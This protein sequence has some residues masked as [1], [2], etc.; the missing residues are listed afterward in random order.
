MLEL[1]HMRKY[2]RMVAKGI[3][4]TVAQNDHSDCC[5][6]SQIDHHLRCCSKMY[7]YCDQTKSENQLSLEFDELCIYNNC[8]TAKRISSN[9]EKGEHWQRPIDSILACGGARSSVSS[10][11]THTV[12]TQKSI[13]YYSI[14]F[15]CMRH[16]ISQCEKHTEEEKVLLK[17]MPRR[18]LLRTIDP[19]S[20]FTGI[21]NRSHIPAVLS[22]Q[23][24]T[25]AH[26]R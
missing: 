11:S 25:P 19:S 6:L 3:A 8:W 12:N 10:W 23:C 13:H 16:S 1:R 17:P 9:A 14:R 22:L 20:Q 15:L 18:R 4:D 26:R 7:Q 5:G 21:L 2:S 24:E